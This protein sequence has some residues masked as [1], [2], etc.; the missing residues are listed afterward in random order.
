MGQTTVAD[1]YV[2]GLVNSG[3]SHNE[4]VYSSGGDNITIRHCWMENPKEQTAVLFLTPG[5]FTSLVIESNYLNGGNYTLYLFGTASPYPQY[6]NNIL[7]PDDVDGLA[8]TTGT[9]YT[10]ACN[11]CLSSEPPWGASLTVCH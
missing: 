7:G 6:E 11:A 10:S 5:M 4:D 1:S 3:D 8:D 9:T 2:H